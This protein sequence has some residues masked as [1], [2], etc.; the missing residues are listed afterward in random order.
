MHPFPVA[1]P[2]QGPWRK[3]TLTLHCTMPTSARQRG[4]R[5]TG[6]THTDV[7]GSIIGDHGGTDLEGGGKLV[8][9][10]SPRQGSRG[11]GNENTNTLLI[12]Y[13]TEGKLLG[14]NIER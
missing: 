6:Q 10:S 9:R 1:S 13:S 3:E 8:R 5:A 11:E 2:H 14:C 12:F 4:A 7:I